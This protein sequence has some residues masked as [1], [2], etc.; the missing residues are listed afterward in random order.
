MV[1]VLPPRW[2]LVRVRKAPT[3]AASR[4]QLPPH[5]QPRRRTLRLVFVHEPECVDGACKL[6]AFGRRHFEAAED[7]SV[8]RAVVSVV[9]ERDVPACSEARQKLEKRAG[10]FGKLEGEEHLVTGGGGAA[11]DH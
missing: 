11:A 6:F 2:P 7:T 10:A 9:E 5:Q 8:G 1:N 4:A 3:W